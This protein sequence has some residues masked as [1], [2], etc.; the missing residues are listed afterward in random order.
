MS[1]DD[2]IE[3][4]A[5]VRVISAMPRYEPGEPYYVVGNL[6]MPSH[7]D[8]LYAGSPRTDNHTAYRNDQSFFAD[9]FAGARRALIDQR[10]RIEELERRLAEETRRR[11]EIERIKP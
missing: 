6:T 3:A 8:Y 10:A 2:I 11:R 5:R 9:P 1:T 7:V 4:L